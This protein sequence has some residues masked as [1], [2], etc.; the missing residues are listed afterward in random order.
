MR[1]SPCV[2]RKNSDYS[3]MV[4]TEKSWAG[5]ATA[6]AMLASRRTHEPW[7]QSSDQIVTRQSAFCWHASSKM[8]SASDEDCPAHSTPSHEENIMN[9]KLAKLALIV[10]ASATSVQRPRLLTKTTPKHRPHHWISH[11]S[12]AG[13][14]PTA[15]QLSP[16]GYASSGLATREIKID[17]CYQV[18]ERQ[19]ASKPCAST[20]VARAPSGH[21]IRSGPRRFRFQTSLPAPMV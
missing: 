16:Y 12:E 21:S 13:G 17:R 6:D 19:A 5:H 11:V 2:R 8:A 15:T 18:L 3:G 14:Q 7:L 4:G 1:F 9:Y 10:A 20:P